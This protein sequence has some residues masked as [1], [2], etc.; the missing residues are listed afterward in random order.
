MSND[1]PKDK[2]NA[3]VPKDSKEIKAKQDARK[4]EPKVQ[5]KKEQVARE[6]VRVSGADLNGNLS[7]DRALR[8]IKGIGYR[9]A[10]YLANDFF[11]KTKLPKKT[12]LG[13][14][15][16]DKDEILNDIVLKISVPEWM[17]NRQRDLYTG[18]SKH[19]TGSDLIFTIREDKQRL[20]RVKARRGM[21]LL[22][23]L[24][25][26]GQKTKSNFRRK[27]GVVGVVKKA[28]VPGKAAPKPAAAKPAPAKAGKK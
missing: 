11:S 5:E 27:M 2:E 6:I 15:P 25:V 26:R 18:D 22:A 10:T 19:L 21:R 13:N 1:K 16:S 17:S 4:Q 28:A 12:L 9:T 7:V 3:Q 24:R 8:S 20:S 14:I 23:G